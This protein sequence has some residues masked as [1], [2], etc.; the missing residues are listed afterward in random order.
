VVSRREKDAAFSERQRRAVCVRSVST[1][2]QNAF[3]RINFIVCFVDR[4]CLTTVLLS[5]YNFSKKLIT[6]LY[7][8]R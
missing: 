4:I 7:I 8:P 1:S 2:N 5:N 3:H 6:D